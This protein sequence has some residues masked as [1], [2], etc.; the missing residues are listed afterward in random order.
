MMDQ[1]STIP[2]THKGRPYDDIKHSIRMVVDSRIRGND[3][4]IV[5]PSIPV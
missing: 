1:V 3:G 2:G 5:I 4:L